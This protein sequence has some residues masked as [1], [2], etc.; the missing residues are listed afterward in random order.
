MDLGSTLLLLSH[1]KEISGVQQLLMVFM[2]VGQGAPC[3]LPSQQL[4]MSMSGGWARRWSFSF[5][6]ENS[7]VQSQAMLEGQCSV[8]SSRN[9]FK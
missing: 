8:K 6:E 1:G 5:L 7:D 2:F 9:I 4:R 3:C